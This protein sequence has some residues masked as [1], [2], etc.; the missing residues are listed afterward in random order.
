[1]PIIKSLPG[2]SGPA[3]VH[4][5]T[6]VEI[7]AT[8]LGLRW[9]GKY[10]SSESGGSA[11]TA[12]GTIAGVPV[13]AITEDPVAAFEQACIAH[14]DN[15]FSG[16][17]YAAPGAAS[18]VGLD[19]ERTLAW[20]RVKASRDAYLNSG[21][22]TPV[23]RFDSDLNTL[24]NL[25]GALDDM[26]EDASQGWILADHTPV[27]M[28]KVQLRALGAAL[29]HLRDSGYARGSALYAQIQAAEDV[30]S[31]RSIVWTPPA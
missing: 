12:F 5:V 6:S 16:G 20:G 22:D 13:T 1:M 7:F 2:A 17:E 8:P 21:V 4:V 19:V 24:V 25:L 23:G 27:T 30:E 28:S 15:V 26:P 14:A 29:K 31:L 18:P 9:V 10:R 3:N 11:P